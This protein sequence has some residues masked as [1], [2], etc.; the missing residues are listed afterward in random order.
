[1]KHARKF[2]VGV[3]VGLS[4]VVAGCIGFMALVFP[5]T[6]LKVTIDN[7]T[8]RPLTNGSYGGWGYAL[9]PAESP[10]RV[11]A[12]HSRVTHVLDQPAASRTTVIRFRVAGVRDDS[13]DVGYQGDAGGLEWTWISAEG[14]SLVKDSSLYASR[15]HP[16]RK[17][18]YRDNVPDTVSKTVSTQK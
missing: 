13:V 10:I 18:R 7:R 1:M 14:D 9:H 4:A 11:I 2:V 12:P 8:D 5:E 15:D 17:Y 3:L 16:A 6:K